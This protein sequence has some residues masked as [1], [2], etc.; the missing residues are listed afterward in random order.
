MDPHDDPAF[1]GALAQSARA[2]VRQVLEHVAV[3][4]H[5]AAF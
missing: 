4:D 3:D 5:R 1:C 2:E